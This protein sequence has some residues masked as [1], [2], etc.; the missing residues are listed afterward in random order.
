MVDRTVD[1]VLMEMVPMEVWEEWAERWG[2]EWDLGDQVD[3]KEWDQ[4]VRED[5]MDQMVL[6]ECMDVAVLD[7]EDLADMDYQEDREDLVG[8]VDLMDPVG[9]EVTVTGVRI[10]ADQW[11]LVD[12]EDQEDQ[13]WEVLRVA[14]EA[15]VDLV[16]QTMATETD[17]T[18]T[19]EWAWAAALEATPT[20]ARTVKTHILK[21]G[22]A[23]LKTTCTD[24]RVT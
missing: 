7:L 2:L 8:R 17:Q 20:P 19:W 9:P 13:I 12:P 11:D 3:R 21:M 10:W 22:P 5:L 1:L 6:A 4:G 15:P 14:W 18:T 23:I 16:D 24:L